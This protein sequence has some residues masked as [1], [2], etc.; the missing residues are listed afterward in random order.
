MGDAGK[1]GKILV[2]FLSPCFAVMIVYTRKIESGFIL[3]WNVETKQN[4]KNFCLPDASAFIP[5]FLK[6]YI[7]C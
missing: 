3:F 2:K 6:I 4:G 7:V 5:F 1:K